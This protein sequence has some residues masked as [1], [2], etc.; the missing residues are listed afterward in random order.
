MKHLYALVVVSLLLLLSACSGISVGISGTP[1][2]VYVKLSK[3]STVY[4][5]SQQYGYKKTLPVM[6]NYLSFNEL[7]STVEFDTNYL[8]SGAGTYDGSYTMLA[9]DDDYI[10]YYDYSSASSLTYGYELYRYYPYKTIPSAYL[11][12]YSYDFSYTV[13]ANTGYFGKGTAHF[14]ELYLAYNPYNFQL[15]K[16]GLGARSA[17][18]S[19]TSVDPSGAITK[20]FVDDEYT[21]TVTITPK[22]GAASASGA[23]PNQP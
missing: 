19:T 3:D 15:I 10:Y 7:P 8:L 16:G 20:A 14:Y 23:K 2:D 1:G 11:D 18:P 6:C 9:Y 12:Y 5:Y 4:T 13:S 22:S 21:V 17:L